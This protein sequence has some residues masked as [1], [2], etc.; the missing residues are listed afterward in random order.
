MIIDIF[1]ALL[2]AVLIW[3]LN[4]RRDLKLQVVVAFMFRLPLIVLSAIH[5]HYLQA[6]LPTRRGAAARRHG[7]RCPTTNH[8]HLGHR[9][10]DNT[11]SEGL[12]ESIPHGVGQ[13]TIW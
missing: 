11:E 9:L 8:H 6:Y 2:P 5:L 1:T 3:P 7:Q 13:H 10:S 12:Y 4:V